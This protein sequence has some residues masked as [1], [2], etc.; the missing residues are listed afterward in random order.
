MNQLTVKV[1]EALGLAEFEAAVTK[2][3]RQRFLYGTKRSTVVVEAMEDIRDMVRVTATA[4]ADVTR[5]HYP[6]HMLERQTTEGLVMLFQTV[7]KF[8]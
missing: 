4:G 3:G 2:D 8:A 1:Q 6:A 7:A 5:K